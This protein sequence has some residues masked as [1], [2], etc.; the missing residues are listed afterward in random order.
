MHL[1][2]LTRTLV[3]PILANFEPL[4]NRAL[5]GLSPSNVSW[6]P[7]IQA[8]SASSSSV[9][10]LLTFRLCRTNCPYSI[11]QHLTVCPM[12]ITS[13]PANADKVPGA[14]SISNSAPHRAGT[15]PPQANRPPGQD[16]RRAPPRPPRGPPSPVKRE[17]NRPPQMQR[18][19]SESSV[20][21]KDR[22]PRIERDRGERPERTE[23][24]ER[25]RRERRR[26]RE[27]RHRREKE[28]T[29]NGEKRPRKPQGLDI[30]DKLDV[31]GIYGQ[32]R[33]YL[34]C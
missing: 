34:P 15:L 11:A 6:T 25:R 13:P 32:G 22:R 14:T 10:C 19:A 29:R 26:E 17:F 31:T 20:M 12:H 4:P 2:C 30:I 24:E 33:E 1:P 16:P 7:H 28:K 18:R 3:S 27:E 5:H 9:K 21:E 8:W 23:S